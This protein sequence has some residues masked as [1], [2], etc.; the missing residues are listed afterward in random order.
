MGGGGRGGKRERVECAFR[1]VCLSNCNLSVS[2]GA[3]FH[4]QRLKLEALESHWPKASTR[5]SFHPPP[6]D[7]KLRGRGTPQA[8]ADAARGLGAIPCYLARAQA[9]NCQ[10]QPRFQKSSR[11]S[12]VAPGGLAAASFSV[13]DGWQWPVPCQISAGCLVQWHDSRFG[14][15]RSQKRAGRPRDCST[16]TAFAAPQGCSSQAAKPTQALDPMVWRSCA[17]LATA[18]IEAVWKHSSAPL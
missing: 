18:G 6:P 10:F 2:M 1:S 12:G 16:A 11:L 3:F 5:R 7:Q 17:T 14:R 13:S 15:E 9:A 8:L 4:C